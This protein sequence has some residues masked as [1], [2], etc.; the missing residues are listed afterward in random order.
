MPLVQLVFATPL[1]RS[2]N[3]FA[4]DASGVQLEKMSVPTGPFDC[5]WREERAMPPCLSLA[6]V[7]PIA[8]FGWTIS[9]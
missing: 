4:S 1:P 7:V 8:R 3:Y 6:D 5:L 9:D 2:R